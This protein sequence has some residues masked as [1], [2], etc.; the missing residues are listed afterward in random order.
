L[1]ALGVACA[2]LMQ[3][4]T[5]I[6]DIGRYVAYWCFAVILPGVLVARATVGTRGNWPEDVALGAVTGLALELVS[7]AI[8]SLL[9]LQQ[10]LWL[11]PLV[12][13]VIF[14]G[15]PRLRRHWRIGSARPLPV[16]W[17]W[18]V[19]AAIAASIPTVRVSAFA[20][21]LPP[22]GGLYYR[23]IPWHLSIVH[24]LTRSFPPQVPQVAGEL[25]S[26]PLVLER[27]PGGR[28]PGL[29]GTRGDGGATAVDH[30]ASRGHGADRSPFGGG[31][32]G[33][34]VVRTGRRLGPD[35]L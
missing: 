1:L 24:E 26:L 22:A 8:W 12:V 10:Q 33:P 30:S 17:S 11:W 29:G 5:P 6:Q 9:G 2:A 7:F 3:T 20:A 15:V 35:R 34:V 23:D 19:A 13:V 4:G 16:W 18:G 31:A 32:V 21:P 27:S 28:A 25:L 14:L